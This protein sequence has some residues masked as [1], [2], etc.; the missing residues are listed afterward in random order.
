M[1]QRTAQRRTRPS[2]FHVEHD[3]TSI[4]S[5]CLISPALASIVANTPPMKRQFMGSR[6]PNSTEPLE[7]LLERL[8]KAEADL[9]SLGA[10]I[11]HLQ[12][13]AMVGTLAAGIVHDINNVLTPALADVQIARLR[14]KHENELTQVLD[15]CILSMTQAGRIAGTLID[16]ALPARER[17]AENSSEDGH[18]MPPSANVAHAIKATIA[19][20]GRRPAEQGVRIDASVPPDVWCSIEPLALQ[21][22]FLNLFLNSLKALAGKSATE[23][24]F[25]PTIR[26][27]ATS[28]NVEDGVAITFEDNGPGILES[29]RS[30]LFQP[31]ATAAT[32][33]TAKGTGLGLTISQRLVTMAGGTVELDQTHHDGTRFLIRLSPMSHLTYAKSA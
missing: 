2:S 16:F 30:T 9:E 21:Q 32:G 10:E 20:L 7:R 13:L 28:G 11:E 29:M 19:C 33:R 5:L 31:F 12:R 8:A 22:V 17:A 26:I 6:T 15:R 23:R 27:S 18:D 14:Q 1:E 24:G 25:E 3:E 4:G